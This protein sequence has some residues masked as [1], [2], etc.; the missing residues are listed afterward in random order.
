MLPFNFSL[1]EWH[2]QQKEDFSCG[3]KINLMGMEPARSYG[4]NLQMR[5]QGGLGLRPN[6]AKISPRPG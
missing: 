5:G 2:S 1:S 4:Q 6:Q 3:E